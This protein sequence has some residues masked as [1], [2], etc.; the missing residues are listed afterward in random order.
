MT[1]VVEIVTTATVLVE[2]VA[3]SV[4]EIVTPGGSVVEVTPIGVV[5]VTTAPG[6]SVVEVATAGVVEVTEAPGVVVVEVAQTGPQGIPGTPSTI[7]GPQ[8]PPGYSGRP[9]AMLVAFPDPAVLWSAA[10]NFPYPPS[11]TTRDSDGIL[12][13]G[14]VEYP[15]GSTVTVSWYS[16]QSGTMELT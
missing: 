5:E 3:A 2:V 14:D 4:V 7:P 15:D 6:I 1:S 12:I 9:V 13:D 11:V 10:H 8:G 16:A